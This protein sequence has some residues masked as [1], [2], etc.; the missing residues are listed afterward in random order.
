MKNWSLIIDKA[1]LRGS[2]NMAVDEFLFNSVR[3]RKRTFLRFYHWEKP[4]VSLGCGQEAGRAVDLAFCRTHGIDVVRRMTGGKVVLHLKELTYSLASS[5]TEMFTSTLQE[6]YELISQA[7]IEGLSFMG[8][9]ARLASA[10]SS[11]YVRATIPCFT[12]PARGE[13]VIGGRKII[14]SAQK[15]AG[16]TFIQH[17][18]VPLDKEEALLKAVARFDTKDTGVNMASLTEAFGR[19]IAFDWATSRFALGFSEFFGIKMKPLTFDEKTWQQIS[20]IETVRYGNA[21]WTL[22]R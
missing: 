12:L 14:G 15:R 22:K 17:G 19:P 7:L 21:A 6:S 18:S 9:S 2:L 1:P 13:V 3:E 20:D 11:T 16:A 8:L 5:D 4:T 10:S